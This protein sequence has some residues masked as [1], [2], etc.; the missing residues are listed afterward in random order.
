MAKAIMD[1]RFVDIP[2]GLPFYKWMLQQETSLTSH[3]LF[4]INADVA[5]SVYYLEDIV[6]Q[7]KR[8][9]QDKSQTKESL[10]HAL[11]TLTMNGCSV[12]DLGLD[13]TLLG[14]P[15]IK[16]K[17]GGKNIPVTIHH[18]EEYLRLVI[19][20]ALNE[21]ISRQLDSF[22]D[23]F[24]SVFPLSHLQYFYLE[25]LDQL[26]CGSKADTWDAKTL[27][28]CCRPDHSFT[29][30]SWAVKFL[31]EILSSFDNE[32]QRLFLQFVTGIPR[33]P[34]GGFQSFNPPLTI[35]RKTFESTEN[36]D[37][38]LPSVMTCVNYLQLLDYS[39]IEIMHEKLLIAAQK[40]QQSFLLS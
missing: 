16:L 34:V 6:R 26:L 31:F 32:H 12:E 38:F 24:E 7:K 28:E 25:E 3:D 22:R 20:W 4:D 9:K 8:L 23:G 17:K 10:Q 37:D 36:R 5:R 35:V 21:G 27:M 40:G 19:F 30:D 29:H 13:F 18:L 14:F 33:L 1:F 11:K 2:L 15:N 39:S